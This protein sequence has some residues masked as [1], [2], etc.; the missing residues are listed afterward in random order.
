MKDMIISFIEDKDNTENFIGS[1]STDVKNLKNDMP[2]GLILYSDEKNI[3]FAYKRH[4][5]ISEYNG[6][7]SSIEN[8]A[9]KNIEDNINYDSIAL[10]LLEEV[11]DQVDVENIIEMY[12]KKNNE[13]NIKIYPDMLLRIRGYISRV[14]KKN[15][16]ALWQNEIGE[17]NNLSIE[18]TLPPNHNLQKNKMFIDGKF[19]FVLSRV[20]SINKKANIQA[21]CIVI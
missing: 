9:I 2:I 3:I 6:T 7:P 13:S 18:L 12:N 21:I 16:I 1:T 14:N 11:N 20:T 17:A 19:V 5:A 15:S 4:L 10:Q 8:I